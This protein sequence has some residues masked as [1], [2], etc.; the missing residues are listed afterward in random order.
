MRYYGIE[1]T[2]G[3]KTTLNKIYDSVD[4]TYTN[5]F[6]YLNFEDSVV[7]KLKNDCIGTAHTAENR[8]GSLRKKYI[9]TLSILTNFYRDTDSYSEEIYK[10]ALDLWDSIKGINDTVTGI[11]SLITKTGNYD[12]IK[13]N[14]KDITVAA[15][16][17]ADVA[18]K[19][20]SF[21]EKYFLNDDGSW[22][23]KAVARYFED[24]DRMIDNNQANTFET[25]C[26]INLINKYL[27]SHDYSDD[28]YSTI[29]NMLIK[30]STEYENK[31]EFNGALYDGTAG[32]DFTMYFKYRNSLGYFLNR[33]NETMNYEYMLT[34]DSNGDIAK[35]AALFDAMA[36][37][38]ST[39]YIALSFFL[40]D[41]ERW[42]LPEDDLQ[43]LLDHAYPSLRITRSIDPD[44]QY[45]LDIRNYGNF[46]GHPS[47][48]DLVT[49][50]DDVFYENTRIDDMH[51]YSCCAQIGAMAD[52][53]QSEEA[54]YQIEGFKVGWGDFLENTLFD[55]AIGLVPNPYVSWILSTGWSAAEAYGTNY[56]IDTFLDYYK[57]LEKIKNYYT[58][59]GAVGCYWVLNPGTDS[60]RVYASPYAFT[61]PQ[62]IEAYLC[63]EYYVNNGTHITPI[64]HA[65]DLLRST[66][67]APNNPSISYAD[68][69]VM[70]QSFWDDYCEYHHYKNPPCLW[71]RLSPADIEKLTIACRQACQ[72]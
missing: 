44:N 15:K 41:E 58:N 18:E 20:V 67:I 36:A 12:G 59:S 32:M 68:F 31:F 48:F 53:Q 69:K 3:L 66:T 62:N 26:L 10:M 5:S 14:P 16:G 34:G 60:Q 50:E 45:Y 17:M 46:N 22:D 33:A 30:C 43:I 71:N 19:Q 47:Y 4:P 35:R 28:S 49:L 70:L 27:Q 25:D 63:Y 29:V 72:D 61:T 57:E 55:T 52:V 11:S 54:R 13:V 39:G 7:T 37:L 42:A 6:C 9:R 64:D 65:D 51:V 23:E 38:S 21:W 2:K 40:T 24:T 1:Y 8:V 56:Q